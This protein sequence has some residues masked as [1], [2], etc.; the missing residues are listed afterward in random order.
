VITLG[1]LKPVLL[2]LRSKTSEILSATVPKDY[3]KD[4]DEASASLRVELYEHDKMI[5]RSNVVFLVNLKDIKSGRSLRRER[6]VR[7]AEQSVGQFL[8]IFGE[9][10]QSDD[11]TALMNFFLYC[12]IPI[13]SA[14]PPVFRGMRPP[15]DYLEGMRSLGARN[16]KVFD[17]L[18]KAAINFIDRHFRK[19][20][21][22]AKDSTSVH[23]H[24][25]CCMQCHYGPDSTC[26]CRS[27]C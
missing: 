26:R 10:L 3:H 12:D 27:S 18:H 19:L 6:Y 7:E 21:R 20:K 5:A 4:F 16:L 14:R 17:V 22:H 2:E 13:E 8:S 11:E 1:D 25:Y 9:L 23:A 15:L 24:R